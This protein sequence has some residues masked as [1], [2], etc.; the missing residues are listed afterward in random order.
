MKTV[1]HE[2]ESRLIARAWKDPE[3]RKQLLRDPKAVLEQ[4]AGEKIPEQTRVVALEE[5]PDVLYLVVPMKPTTAPQLSPERL[6]ALASG[7]APMPCTSD[8]E[9]R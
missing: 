2:L 1:R 8:E 4:E 5:R 3:F 7:E 6:L 9:R